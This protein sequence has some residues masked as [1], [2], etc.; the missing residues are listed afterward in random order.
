MDQEAHAAAGDQPPVPP[1]AP[2]ERPIHP[3]P[4]PGRKAVRRGKTKATAVTRGGSGALKRTRLRRKTPLRVR[5]R[6]HR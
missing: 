1:A 6:V 5:S 2:V 3:A 4:K